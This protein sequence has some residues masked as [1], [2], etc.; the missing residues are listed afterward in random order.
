MIRIFITP[1]WCS[2]RHP[3]KAD[4]SPNRA[5]GTNEA[6]PYRSCG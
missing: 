4:G 2:R 3:P 6:R 5:I 1:F